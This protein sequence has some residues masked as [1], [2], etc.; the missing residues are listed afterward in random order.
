VYLNNTY[1]NLLVGRVSLTILLIFLN[2]CNSHPDTT[3]T[4][5]SEFSSDKILHNDTLTVFCT[6]DQ[7]QLTSQIIKKIQENYNGLQTEITLFERR[8]PIEGLSLGRRFA[9]LF[10]IINNKQVFA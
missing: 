10:K 2:A 3:E 6:E 1:A 5:R 7:F 8:I 4:S 9:I